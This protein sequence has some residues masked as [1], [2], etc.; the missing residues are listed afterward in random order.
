MKV[1]TD[2]CLFG[3]WIADKI[4]QKKINP[5]TILD[6]GTGTGL[7]SLMLAQKSSAQI[8]AVEI[9]ENAFAQAKENF[10]ASPWNERLHA[11]H[12]DIKKWNAPGKYYLIIS[13][14]PFFE[15]DLLPED[16]GKNISKH[17]ST[18]RLEELLSIARNLLNEEG[19]FAILLPWHRAKCF[20]S[21]ASAQSLFVKEIMEVKQTTPHSFFRTIFI[22]QKQKTVTLK[23]ELSIKNND[24]QYTAEFIEL[25]KDYYLYL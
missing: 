25:L 2:S 4:E 7:L 16:E 23:S 11:F 22:L 24:N 13:N 6:I 3:A 15:N 18:M 10:N 21:E 20:E 9:D 14:P 19:N 5:K 17:S 1:C 8:D 12:S